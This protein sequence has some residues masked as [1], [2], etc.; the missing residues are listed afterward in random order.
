MVPGRGYFN[1]LIELFLQFQHPYNLEI[2]SS[3]QYILSSNIVCMKQ[4]FLSMSLGWSLVKV[5]QN[6]GYNN[7]FPD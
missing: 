6:Y 4:R 1:H 5:V 2:K 7:L 3:V